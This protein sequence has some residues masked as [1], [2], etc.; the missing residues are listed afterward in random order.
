MNEK[1][2]APPEYVGRPLDVEPRGGYKAPARPQLHFSSLDR[3]WV[4]GEQFY[5]I[6]VVG[7]RQDTNAN[8]IVGIAVD[9]SVSRNMEEKLTTGRLL[10]LEE[11]KA[12]ARDT[13]LTE[14]ELKTVV[15]DREE[16]LI[17]EA[18][19]KAEAIDK[20]VR[21]AS[22]HAREAAPNINPTHVQRRWAIEIPGLPFDLVGAIDV[23]EG[24]VAGRDTK[25][26]G[27]TPNQAIADMSMQLTI[28][29]LAILVLDGAA[30]EEMVLDYLVDN[31]LPVYRQFRSTRDADDYRVLMNRIENAAEV[32]QKGAFVPAQPTD[33]HCSLD[34]C[35]FARTCRYFQRPKSM[36][37]NPGGPHVRESSAARDTDKPQRRLL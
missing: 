36:V 21:L 10:P 25:T 9:A 22:L 3:L 13:V 5:R 26:S 17:G 2:T 1:E 4:C 30:P 28:Y 35:S 33:W 7:E 16:K 24:L 12:I 29:S 23:Q 31:K 32:I 34:F 20:A 8:L 6:Y 15:L 37:I 19:V 18:A 11:A 27:K 14:W